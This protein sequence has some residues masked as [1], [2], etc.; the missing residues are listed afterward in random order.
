MQETG[1]KWELLQDITLRDSTG[2]KIYEAYDADLACKECRNQKLFSDPLMK[3]QIFQGTG[4]GVLQP[5]IKR[6]QVQTAYKGG[7]FVSFFLSFV[8]FSL[9]L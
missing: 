1:S 3:E 5:I 9:R 6:E 7:G 8:Y 4:K 2:G